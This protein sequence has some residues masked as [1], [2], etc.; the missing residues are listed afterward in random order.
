ML[1][2]CVNKKHYYIAHFRGPSYQHHA[3]MMIKLEEV[4]CSDRGGGERRNMQSTGRCC[5][6]QQ[7]H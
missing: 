7:N 5:Y 4:L 1:P 2:L 3:L 6:P